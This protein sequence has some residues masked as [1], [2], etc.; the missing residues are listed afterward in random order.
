M[1]RG[2]FKCAVTLDEQYEVLIFK[3]A[4]GLGFDAPRAF[5]L[6]SLR[7]A[8][9]TDFGIQ[10]VGRLL[11]VHRL[12]QPGTL[13]RTLPSGLHYGYVFLADAENQSGLLSAGERINAVR[14]ELAQI[15][16]GRSNTGIATSR[17]NP[18]R[19]PS[20]CPLARSS[21]PILW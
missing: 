20:H 19:S 8:K 17:I 15:C 10:V 16:P 5:V 12:L 4:V 9:D 14:D 6:A 7:G 1:F 18:G 11:R 21:S 13:D 3:V 2:R